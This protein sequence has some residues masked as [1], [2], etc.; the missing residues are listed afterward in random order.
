MMITKYEFRGEKDGISL[1]IL[2]AV[3]GNE[4]AGTQA[5][6]RIIDEFNRG[7]L[8]L[9]GG[10]LTLVPVCNP[11]A[12]R[13]DVRSIDENLNRVIKMHDNP[14]SYE[15]RLA[16]EICPLIRSHRFTLDLHSTHCVGDVPFAF[17][18][19]PDDYN[20]K[21]IEALPVDYVLEGWPEIYGRQAQIQDFSTEQCAHVY[22]NTATT[23]ECGYHKEPKAAELAY[24]AIIGALAAFDMVD[25]SKPAAHEKTH[26]QMKSFVLKPGK[27]SCAGTINIWILWL[28]ER[29]SP[30]MTAGSFCML[31]KMVLFCCLICRLRLIRSGII[32]GR[33]KKRPKMRPLYL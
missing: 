32:W 27:E 5:C 15:Q 28:K 3:H 12:Y 24:R 19:Y 23:L 8:R 9:T 2:A 33:Q 1:L 22:G 26:I 31:R 29:K 25:L 14:Q 6:F 13:K 7:A 4:T 10:H 16:N 17:C 30:F 11:E 20:R 18:D 21:V